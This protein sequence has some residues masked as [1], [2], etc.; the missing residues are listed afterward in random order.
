MIRNCS[1]R[2]HINSLCIN[3]RLITCHDDEFKCKLTGRCLPRSD[4]KNDNYD[5][6]STTQVQISDFQYQLVNVFLQK[7]DSDESSPLASCLPKKE[8]RCVTSQRCIPREWVHDDVIDCQDGSDEDNELKLVCDGELEFACRSG[9]RCLLRHRVN[10]GFSDCDDQSDENNFNFICDIRSEFDCGDGRCIPRVWIGNGIVECKSG[11]DEAKPMTSCRDDEFSCNDN[12]RC[13]PLKYKCDGIRNCKDGSD[14]VELCD[15]PHMFTCINNPQI[16]V[17]WSWTFNSHL[18]TS[19]PDK[20]AAY[21]QMLIG[22]KCRPKF[23]EDKMRRVLVPQIYIHNNISVCENNL[24]A[25][26]DSENR[27]TCYK[28]LDNKT[29]IS[30]DQICDNVVDCPDLSDECTCLRSSAEPLCKRVFENPARNFSLSVICDGRQDTNDGIDEMFCD[31]TSWGTDNATS[32]SSDYKCKLFELDEKARKF[33]ENKVVKYCDGKVDCPLKDDECQPDCIS[34]SLWPVCHTTELQCHWVNTGFLI[35]DQK[36]LNYIRCNGK[37]ECENNVDEMDCP[38]RFH[39]IPKGGNSSVSFE[40][41]RWCDL[42]IDCNDGRDELNCS[43]NTHFY[44]ANKDPLFIQKN[45]Y[46]DGAQDCSDNSDEC[47]SNDFSSANELIKNHFLK[48][49]VWFSSTITLVANIIVMTNNIKKLQTIP[50]KHSVSYVN[51]LLVTHLAFSDMLMGIALFLLAVNSKSFEG[52]YCINDRIWRSGSTCNLIGALT[53]VSSQTSLNILVILTGFRAYITIKPFATDTLNL[54]ICN[55]M[56]M[57]AWLQPL[58]FAIFPLICYDIFAEAYIIEKTPFFKGEYANK[59]DIMKF[60]NRT[61]ETLTR[62]NTSYIDIG[63]Y[64]W[65]H[66]EASSRY[67]SFFINIKRVFTYYGS[68]GVCFPDL[69]AKSLP[70][71]A[72]S[73][74]IILYNIMALSFIAICYIIIYKKSTE[75]M[76]SSFES[77]TDQTKKDEETLK[78]RILYV[79]LADKLCWFPIIIMAIFSY[80]NHTL[81]ELAHSVSII[82]LLPIQSAVNPIIYSRFDRFLFEKGKKIFEMVYPSKKRIETL[83]KDKTDFE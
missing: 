54:A 52:Q 26:Y 27:F 9:S 20:S 48:N 23:A 41:E 56:I 1:S 45:L 10:D 44:C 78:R 74:S 70:A 32:S 60:H 4:V 53:V 3:Y 46:V 8:F 25:C 58:A 24:D 61:W 57:F 81:P 83:V 12:T 11:L 36:L 63:W 37:Q 38:W 65:Y 71:F 67:P 49:F 22:F 62:L 28:C 40:A 17:P 77:Y 14:E 34:K 13:L 66:M 15:E 51:T 31:N 50:Y 6:D 19:C 59:S 82:L 39:C 43:S 29:I 64:D 73:F 75:I 68:F 72:L 79:V 55:V 30:K 33:Y 69:F 21:T 35:T 47:L 16:K 2:K 5:C 7:D 18:Y 80:T 42:N 76:K